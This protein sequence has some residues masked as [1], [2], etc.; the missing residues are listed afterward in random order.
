MLIQRLNSLLPA[1]VLL[2]FVVVGSAPASAG[3]IANGDFAAKGT[4]P[5]P[6]ADWTTD[7]GFDAPTDG[8]QVARFSI[9][10]FADPFVHLLQTFQLMSGDQRLTF[11]FLFTTAS[12]GNMSGSAGQMIDDSFQATLY[13]SMDMPVNPV[14]ALLPAF[15]AM[16][17]AGREFKPTQGVTVSPP[18][19]AGWKRVTL[20]VANVALLNPGDYTIEFFV[21]GGN[22]GRMIT[23]DVDNVALGRDTAVIPEPASLAIWGIL[24]AGAVLRRRRTIAAS[25]AA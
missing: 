17:A 16:D 3:V 21:L 1:V 13:D 25:V 14:N 24:G 7:S 11:D 18:D 12:G 23:V 9:T 15:F 10:N 20:D 8:G 6:F 2:A 4:L 19:M 22:D 5:P